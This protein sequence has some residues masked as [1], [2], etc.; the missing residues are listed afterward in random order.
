MAKLR[1]MLGS[2]EDPY[3]ISLMRLIETQ[4]KVTLATWAID[5]AENNFLKIY[6]Q[7][8][9]DDHRLYNVIAAS[10]EFINGTRKLSEVKLLLKEAKQIAKEVEQNPVTYASVRAI[11]TA[12]AT[13][14]TPTNALGFTFYGAAALVYHLVGLS[15]DVKT[16]DELA[17]IEL[18]KMLKS[19]Q[20]VAIENEEHP[21]KI[22][23]NC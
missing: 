20:S 17:S 21:V 15:E 4:S 7:D 18:E 9:P 2:I 12:C 13:I 3:I 14:Q 11:A 22:N 6:E 1:K 19:L 16:Y 10:K 23:W 5:Y 8:Y